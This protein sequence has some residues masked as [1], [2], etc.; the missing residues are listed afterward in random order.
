MKIS[1]NDANV[2]HEKVHIHGSHKRRPCMHYVS[3]LTKIQQ[4]NNTHPIQYVY[5]TST[6]NLW[7]ISVFE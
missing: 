3:A 2:L 6:L 1:N 5:Q 7:S 4:L